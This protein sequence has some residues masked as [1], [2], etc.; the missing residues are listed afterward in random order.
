MENEKK[1]EIGVGQSSE[2]YD[3]YYKQ[4]Y[5]YLGQKV[6][7][8]E[9]IDFFLCLIDDSGLDVVEKSEIINFTCSS[10]KYD[11]YDLGKFDQIDLDGLNHRHILGI[12]KPNLETLVK[13]IADSTVEFEE[14]MLLLTFLS[15]DILA[16]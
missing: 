9:I 6:K 8:K 1:I 12:E 3:Y 16:N 14:K 15:A 4:V 7:E 13:L 5:S 11:N 10:I 2:R